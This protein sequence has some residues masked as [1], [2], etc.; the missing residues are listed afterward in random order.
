MLNL[1][2]GWYSEERT[3]VEHNRDAKGAPNSTVLE[4]LE[5]KRVSKIRGCGF[6]C[7]TYL[8][9]HHWVLAVLLPE[10][11]DWDQQN[12]NDKWCNYLCCLPL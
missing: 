5:P 12:T 10:N 9:W 2:H 4:K 8:E 1:N 3:S 11:P 7:L 6:E